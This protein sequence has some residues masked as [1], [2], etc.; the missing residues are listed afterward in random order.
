MIQTIAATGDLT[1]SPD[2]LVDEVPG[3][4]SLDTLGLSDKA[5]KRSVHFA[6]NVSEVVGRVL[7]RDDF[8]EDEKAD[9]WLERKEFVQIQSNAKVVVM[10]VKKHGS[11]YVNCIDDSY[12]TAQHL[13]EFMVEGEAI[14]LFFEDPSCYT[15]KMEMW[16]EADY[17][18]RG[19][20][21]Y[22][23]PLQ[24]SQRALE[25]R[26]TRLMVLIAA[27]KGIGH[28][29]L[30]EIYSAL[31]WMTCLYSRMIGHA[32]YT[33]AYSAEDS[34]EHFSEQLPE[35]LHPVQ[36]SDINNEHYSEP[37]IQNLKEVQAV[38]NQA[39]KLHSAS[40]ETQVSR[41]A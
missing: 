3:D 34:L 20:E 5:R 1:P 27:D 26:E 41:A 28:N 17:G 4:I 33:V 14:D 11:A 19:L 24:K 39:L 12:K 21:R 10:A 30:A 18:Q 32:D 38:P 15:E 16:S 23:S 9:Y 40:Q 8:S 35:Q 7:S 2:L 22:I 25:T 6:P 36:A 13:S 31:S 37:F 29:E